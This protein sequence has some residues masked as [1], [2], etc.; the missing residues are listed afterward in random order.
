MNLIRVIY[1]LMFVQILSKEWAIIKLYARVVQKRYFNCIPIII[2]DY[3][4]FATDGMCNNTNPYEAI[5]FELKKNTKTFY[6][7]EFLNLCW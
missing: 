2:E 6:H 7:Q 1:V 3:I 5:V 4:K